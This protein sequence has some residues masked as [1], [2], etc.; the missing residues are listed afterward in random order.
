MTASAQV[1]ISGLTITGGYLTGAAQDGGGILNS[2]TLA[3]TGCTISDNSASDG[4]GI[5]NLGGTLAATGC[6]LHGNSA[7][8]GGGGIFNSHNAAFGEGVLTV[9]DSTI[10]GNSV[11]G[12]GGGGLYN[13]SQGTTTITASTISGNSTSGGYF[14]G[15]LLNNYVGK[16]FITNSTVYGNS[17]GG[18]GGGIGAN[19][20]VEVIDCTISGNSSYGNTASG[21]YGGLYVTV[22]ASIVS[23]P[24]GNILGPIS[25]GGHNLFS[26]SSDVSLQPT[27]L[28][29]TDPLLGPLAD[30]GG[31]TMT[32]G[33]LPGSPAIGAG[34]A[35]PGVTTDQ[36]GIARPQNSAPDIGAFQHSGPFIVLTPATATEMV[37][38]THTVTV[39][40]LDQN[41]NPLAGV[42]VAFQVTAGPNAGA[43]GATD[44]ADGLTDAAGHLSFTYTG[45][46]GLGTD[47]IVASTANPAGGTLFATPVTVTWAAPQVM[48]TPAVGTNSVGLSQ[49]FTAMVAAPDGTPLAGLPVSFRIT[50]GPNA[51][52]SGTTDP[53]DGNTDAAGKVR[54]TYADAGGFGTD[55][56][57]ATVTLPGGQTFDSPVATAV[58]STLTVTNTNDSGAGS[59]PR[60]S[61]WPTST[62]PTRR[63]PSHPDS[64]ARSSF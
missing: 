31:P 14:G 26:G 8:D 38:A 55:S 41:A 58:W 42:P 40:L 10:S 62:R 51:G 63:S 46:A 23:N 30:N 50:K 37:G 52:A 20:E 47:T 2:G 4:G 53:A 33:L 9:T 28:V 3:V 56:L 11:S 7:S 13:D 39:T 21:I 36:R 48:L 6:T 19:D 45:S 27:D 24:R 12:G 25:S 49:T 57:V 29:S 16:L 5:A 54:F 43:V 59:L 15:G 60:P 34:V 22:T 32:L 1:A 17:A 35:I 64:P 44:P 18:F 61:R